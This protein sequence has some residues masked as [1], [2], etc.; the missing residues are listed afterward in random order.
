[1]G[2]D[3]ETNNWKEC[4]QRNNRGLCGAVE[5]PRP[6]LLMEEEE[7]EER[8]VEAAFPEGRREQA[9]GRPRGGLRGACAWRAPE[10]PGHWGTGRACRWSEV[11]PS[12]A[13]TTG[14]GC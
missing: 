3:L 6:E 10:L 13:G 2:A 5:G 11:V 14:P 12:R 8:R 1:M 9:L 4:D 7:E